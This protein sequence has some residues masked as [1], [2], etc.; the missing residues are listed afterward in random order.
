MVRFFRSRVT[1]SAI[2]GGVIVDG[3]RRHECPQ[4]VATAATERA[5]F[6]VKQDRAHVVLM[7]NRKV[8]NKVAVS[9]R[10]D[11]TRGF[12]DVAKMICRWN[13]VVCDHLVS[14]YRPEATQRR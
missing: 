2:N 5:P 11:Q 6:T 12:G 9:G 13:Q 14:A 1:S 7:G 8:D 4:T 3:H 10:C